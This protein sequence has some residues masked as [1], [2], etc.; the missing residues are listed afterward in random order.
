LT[1]K[2]N[3]YV[4]DKKKKKCL[5]PVPDNQLA[6]SVKI[7]IAI[8]ESPPTPSKKKKKIRAG[9]LNSKKRKQKKSCRGSGREKKFLRAEK[10]P[11]SPYHFSNGPPLMSGSSS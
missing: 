6:S 10:V 4:K 5:K 8:L 11:P 9:D 7:K 3:G 1:V 2:Q